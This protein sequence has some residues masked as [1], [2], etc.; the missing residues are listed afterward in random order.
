M[1]VFVLEFIALLSFAL[2]YACLNTSSSVSYRTLSK[3]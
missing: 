2:F 3:S 1:P